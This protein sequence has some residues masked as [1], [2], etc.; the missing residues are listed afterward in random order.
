M[1]D[2]EIA[3]TVNVLRGIAVKYHDHQSLRGRIADV[4]V[5]P[6]KRIAELE[7]QNRH[8]DEADTKCRELL[9]QERDE[10]ESKSLIYREALE[11]IVKHLEMTAG[12]MAPV[13]GVYVIATKALTR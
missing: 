10:A 7:A 6:L 13:S 4:V 3:Q 1:K 8:D 2:H 9:C 5:Y 11:H 12:G